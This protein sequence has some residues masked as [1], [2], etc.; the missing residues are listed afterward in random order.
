IEELNEAVRGIDIHPLS[1]QIAKTTMLIA[2][3]KEVINAKSPIFIDIMLANTILLP[4]GIGDMFGSEFLMEIDDAKIPLT[5]E[6]FNS[7]EIY[8]KAVA[9]ADDLA[10]RQGEVLT[11][12]T[13]EANL[14]NK[15]G[16]LEIDGQSR[17]GFYKIYEKF[18][19]VKDIG[20]DSIWRFI[21]QNLYK[22]YFLKEKFDYV[23]CN[24]PW[25]TYKDIKNNI[26][27][28]T[29]AKLADEYN[30]KPASG[31]NFTNLEI[32][33]IFMAHCSDYFLKES[34]EIAFVLPRSFFSADHHDNTRSGEAIGFRL[35]E[36][37][38]LD[39]VS[40]LFR[41]PS[42]VLFG[43]KD[44]RE[45]KSKTTNFQGKLFK[46]RLKKHNS[47]WQETEELLKET[48]A[49]LYYVR[50]GNSTA[51]SQINT[52][53]RNEPNPYKKDFRRGAEITP[54]SFYF[55]D[56]NQQKPPD[57]EDRIIN[58]RTAEAVHRDAKK[59]W[60]NIDLQGRIESRFLFRTALS[61]SLLPFALFAPELVVLPLT[62]EESEFGKKIK[63]H[64]SN[65]LLEI[66]FSDASDWFEKA[67]KIWNEKKTSSNEGNSAIDYLD[68]QNK[69][70]SQ[71]I[72][73][74]YLVIYNA[75]GKDANANVF[76]RNDLEFEFIVDTKGYSFSTHNLDEANY[77][78]SVLNSNVTNILM[79]DFQSRGLF[80]A[81]DVHKKILDIYYP[82][83]DR[84]NELHKQ[85][86]DL[87]KTAHTKAKE[88]LRE[89][90][91][92]ADLSPHELGKIRLDVKRFLSD[93]M[94][95]ID[96]LVQNLIS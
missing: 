73:S 78:A 72:N 89:T 51:F 55:V 30:V 83:F 49:T 46:G 45:S 44:S 90:S 47:N 3:G 16:G 95:Q 62:I 80:G 12:A 34:G 79:K 27:R 35:K 69:L 5:T 10:N 59:P 57:F 20:R 38:D 2:Y 96:V 56:I 50:Q 60:T 7:I 18:K 74:P 39:E 1:V 65:E 67:E 70:T 82:R 94:T 48:D 41:V 13:F 76:K 93:E 9:V 61:K 77:L 58:I 92:S 85:L 54:R 81:R 36:G 88:F 66:G 53:S 11:Q 15:L 91:P 86:A 87:S 68:Y 23:I 14:K 43:I 71:D 32:A 4:Q 37:W 24:P 21:L 19:S 63:L 29:L 6:I 17:E 25:F 22:P 42:C 52:K 40:P 28:E 64:S 8:D 31:K 33:A 26:Y 75:S 84:E